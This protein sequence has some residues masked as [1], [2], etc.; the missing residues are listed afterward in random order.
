M[1]RPPSLLAVFNRRVANGVWTI[2]DVAEDA[3]DL[4]TGHGWVPMH[5]EID[6]ATD[7]RTLLETIGAAGQFP[8]H[9]GVNWDAA[10]D[11]LSDLSWLDEPHR[12]SP[13]LMV[14]AGA[15]AWAERN[16]RDATILLDVLSE[17]ALWWEVNGRPF[18]VLWHGRRAP[19]PC[20]DLV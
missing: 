3:P 19:I 20:L 12:R 4:A 9:Y 8:P 13:V 11:H 7:K 6:P 15:E 14:L 2:D 1:A 17:A 5:V 18:V 16:E 10:A